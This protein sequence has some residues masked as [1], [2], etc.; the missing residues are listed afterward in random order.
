MLFYPVCRNCNEPLADKR[1]KYIAE[2]IKKYESYDR[3]IYTYDN[4]DNEIFKK[5]GIKNTC[6]KIK[7]KTNLQ[8]VSNVTYVRTLDKR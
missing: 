7:L 3:I 5:I 8:L 1:D 2:M 4:D 6:C